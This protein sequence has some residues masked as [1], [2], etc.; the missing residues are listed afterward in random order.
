MVPGD[1]N[2]VPMNF[3]LQLLRT[4]ARSVDLIGKVPIRLNLHLSGMVTHLLNKRQSK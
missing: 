1:D 3:N 2:L 4:E